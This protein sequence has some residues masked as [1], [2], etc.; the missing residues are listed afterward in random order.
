MYRET[1]HT[2]FDWT[3]TDTWD[4]IPTL[5]LELTPGTGTCWRALPLRICA[6]LRP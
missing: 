2:H 1:L 4:G 6:R 5:T 3:G